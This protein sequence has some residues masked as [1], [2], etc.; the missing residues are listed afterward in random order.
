MSSNVAVN[1]H[2]LSHEFVPDKIL[3][4]DKEVARLSSALG[5]ANSFVHGR[6][7]IGKTLLVKKAIEGS[8]QAK[9]GRAIYLDAALYQTTNAVLTET[10]TSLGNIVTSK[11]N[12]DLTKRLQ[13]KLRH[14]DC[15]VTV[16]IDHFERLKETEIVDIIL[17]LGLGLMIIA[18]SK[19]SY[20]RLSA[21]A[22]ANVTN[23]IEILA[24]SS[25]Q[26]LG[27]LE[28]RARQALAD[29]TYSTATLK[30]IADLSQGNVTLALGLLKSLV[31]KAESEG[32]SS[33]DEV[34]IN[35]EAD[36]PDET[37]TRDE[38]VL[39]KILEEWKSLPSSRLF[40]FYREKAPQPP[41][42]SC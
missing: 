40:A 5:F 30:K 17:S 9:A 4:R 26:V 27:I 34:E 19:E 13:A 2:A 33:I 24:N 23:M 29:Y 28:E 36:C 15:R 18:E 8:D 10:L 41:L 6:T 42:Q 7:G 31:L 35:Y 1:L 16:C 38:R 32:K 25:N 12:Y 22:R 3:H 21:Q 20:R 39:L 14:L 37:L 11:S